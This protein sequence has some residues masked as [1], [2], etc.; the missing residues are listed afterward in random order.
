[1]E[2]KV[3]I[4]ERPVRPDEILAAIGADGHGGQAIFLGVVRDTN[5]GRRVIEVDYDCFVPLARRELARIVEEARA[6]WG[7]DLCL[8]VLHATGRVKVGEASV[9]IGVSSPHRSEAFL[10]CRY[11]IE[12]IKTRVPI[13]KR[14]FYTDGESGWVE[15]HSLCRHSGSP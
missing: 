7:G 15:G 12:Q 2:P 5:D 10:A 14:E 9:G 13:W 4:L 1:M 6:W 8:C 3:E 11:V